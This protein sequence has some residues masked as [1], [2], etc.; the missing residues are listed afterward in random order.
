MKEKRR[1]KRKDG[2][3]VMEAGE[4]SLRSNGSDAVATVQVILSGVA[5]EHVPCSP[6]SH[7]QQAREEEGGF[8]E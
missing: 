1:N 8:E 5:D 4:Y 3:T 2:R 7:S 6:H